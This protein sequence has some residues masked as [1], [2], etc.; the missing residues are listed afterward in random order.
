MGDRVGPSAWHSKPLLCA[1][2]TL[3]C[4]ACKP[5]AGRHVNPALHGM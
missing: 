3:C 5:C 2:Q 4:T 1:M